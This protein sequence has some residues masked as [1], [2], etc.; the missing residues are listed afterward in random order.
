MYLFRQIHRAPSALSASEEIAFRSE[1]AFCAW[2]YCDVTAP[3]RFSSDA[4]AL[5]YFVAFVSA[6]SSHM[7]T[8]MWR[9]IITFLGN[10]CG[11]G[12]G[13]V[14]AAE[15]TLLCQS[16]FERET[17]QLSAK[18]GCWESI[19]EAY[20]EVLKGD[21]STG[22]WPAAGA[23]AARALALAAAVPTAGPGGHARAHSPAVLTM[24]F[25]LTT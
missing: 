2:I 4:S 25:H 13:G 8:V 23:D 1:H 9:Q 24:N 11:R 21:A 3:S 14:R 7:V 15:E 22:P 18:V 12:R 10:L 20:E 16:A 6:A 5:C 17:S 19:H